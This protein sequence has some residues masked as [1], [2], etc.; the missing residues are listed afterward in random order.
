MYTLLLVAKEE[1]AFLLTVTKEDL[2]HFFEVKIAIKVLG[3]IINVLMGIHTISSLWS[4]LCTN[5]NVIRIFTIKFI[6]VSAAEAAWAPSTLCILRQTL[7]TQ[8]MH[9]FVY[10]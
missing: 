6:Y 5:T 1:V 9:H 7:G 2:L 8:Q 10:A 4:F 3:N